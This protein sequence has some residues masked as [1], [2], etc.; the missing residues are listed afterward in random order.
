MIHDDEIGEELLAWVCGGEVGAVSQAISESEFGIDPP[1]MAISWAGREAN[2]MYDN[3]YVPGAGDAP[4]ASSPVS[5]DVGWVD[6]WYDAEPAN[7]DA[8]FDDEPFFRGAY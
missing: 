6:A 4:E 3:D 2:A 7:S 5:A 1:R 8:A